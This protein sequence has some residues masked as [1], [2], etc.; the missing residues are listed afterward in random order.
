MYLPRLHFK[1][2]TFMLSYDTQICLLSS[3]FQNDYPKAKYP[4][5][6]RK[7]QRPYTCLLVETHY[8][9]YVGIPFRSDIK[10]SNAYKFNAAGSSRQNPGLDYTKIVIIQDDDYIDSQ[11]PAVV[12][13]NEYNELMKN[14]NRIVN[15]SVK[16]VETY[17]NHMKGTRII[18][19]REYS[20]RYAYSTLMYFHK[21][22][23]I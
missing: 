3:K 23:G 4:E 19:P 7:P 5:L 11:T 16:Y 15:E 8:D 13:Q 1:E 2:G 9:Y 14:L 18:H 17:V 20:R 21:E 6:L 22:L 10:H 12:D